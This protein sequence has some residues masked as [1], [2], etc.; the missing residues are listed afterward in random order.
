MSKTGIFYGSSNGTTEGIA[1]KI[2]AKLGVE[3]KDIHDVASAKVNDL[4]EYEV[5]LLGSS[6]WGIGDLQDDWE[7]FIKVLSSA[8]LSGKKVALFGCGDSSSYPDSFC[9]AVGKIYQVVKGVSTVIGFTSTEGYSFDASEAVVD[10][11]FVGLILDEENERNLSEKRIEG[12]IAELKTE[13]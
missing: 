6:T 4:D 3:Q 13:I 2:A 9:D 1:K 10:H 11:R 5:L 7:S 8:N 12:W